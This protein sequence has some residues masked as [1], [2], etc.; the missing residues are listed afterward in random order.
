MSGI[1]SLS[2]NI[3][4]FLYIFSVLLLINCG[5][6]STEN[7]CD[8]SSNTFLNTQLLKFL[9]ND[10]SSTCGVAAVECGI[11][12]K[13]EAANIVIGQPDFVSNTAGTGDNQNQGAWGIT[14]DNK[15]G[16]WIAD[17]N[18]SR[19]LHFS[20][21]Q[22]TYQSA[23]IILTDTFIVP[24]A[25]AAD[26]AGGLW[27]T[28]STLSGNAVL[29]FPAGMSTGDL[30]DIMLGTGTLGAS[31]NQVTNPFG[32]G[33][34]PSGGVLV[35]DYGANRIVHFSPPF[36]NSMNADFVLGQANFT[37]ASI[38]LSANQM[39]GPMEVR[40]DPSGKI[41]VSDRGNNRI[42]RFSPPFISGMNADLVLGQP[43]FVT[44]N[45]GT[46]ASTFSSPT[47]I[48]FDLAGR[49]WIA[50]SSNSRALRFSPPFTNG[51]AADNVIGKSDF[52]TNT[53]SGINAKEIGNTT[54]VAIAPCGLWVSD[55]SNN[56]VLFFP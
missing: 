34:D 5:A 54:S 9:L 28:S 6:I 37:S 55:S 10:T 22:R 29:H 51:M 30:H 1:F 35:A 43:D 15:G 36:T 16:L 12:K 40:A 8:P 19:V 33:V 13:G 41:W 47:G 11:L 45:F 56:R 7:P 25:I 27:V 17:T 21:P 18:V 53:N 38:G 3:K 26:A 52:I 14:V 44:S 46:D 39:N 42:L 48:S 2:K 49:V 20:V 4:K 24:R 23:D 50:D 32:V 31:I